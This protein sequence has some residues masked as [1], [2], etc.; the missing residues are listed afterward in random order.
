MIIET[1]LLI[2]A[3]LSTIIGCYY[4][5]NNFRKIEKQEVEETETDELPH[6]I[7]RSFGFSLLGFLFLT[8][9]SIFIVL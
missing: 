1:I 7:K 6:N 3:V 2:I 4:F 5:I 9:L 8:L